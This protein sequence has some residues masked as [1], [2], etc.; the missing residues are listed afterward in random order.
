MTKRGPSEADRFWSKVRPEPGDGCWLW[1][2]STVRGYGSFRL[3]RRGSERI[4]RGV[5]AHRWSWEA[6][7]G[8]I[9]AGLHVCHRCDV[10]R[11]VNPA[12][13]F[14]GTAL[15]NQRDCKAK[16]RVPKGARRAGAKLTDDAV[17]EVR[18]RYAAGGVSQDALAAEMGVSQEAIGRVLRGK[19]WN[20]VVNETEQP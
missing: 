4:A 20:H 17:R 10:P 19:T 16:G 6:H 9:A 1:T 11:C 13:L 8:P 18:S 14:L 5:K 2:G 7:Y 15:E 12:H 3:T